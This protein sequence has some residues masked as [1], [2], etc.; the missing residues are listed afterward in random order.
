[1]ENEPL[2]VWVMEYFD[3]VAGD[4]SIDLY[5]TEEMARDDA[6]KLEADGTISSVIIYQR[7][8]WQ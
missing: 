8:V 4:S 6:A 7:R 2:I 1:M 3:D 5:K